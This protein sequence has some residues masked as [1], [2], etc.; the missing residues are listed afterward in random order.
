[1]SAQRTQRIRQNEEQIRKEEQ[2]RANQKRILEQKAMIY[3]R[4]AKGERL[5]YE[6]G[7]EA[8]FLVDFH[9]KKRE[10]EQQAIGDEKPSS[11]GADGERR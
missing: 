9:S 6:D 1:M 2:Q 4:M 5:V 10:L 8:E 11:S 7:K 3:E